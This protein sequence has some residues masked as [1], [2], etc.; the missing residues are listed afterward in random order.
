MAKFERG[1]HPSPLLVGGLVLLALAA[2][3]LGAYTVIGSYVDADGWLHE[4][5]AFIPLAWL[6]GLAGAVLFVVV[7]VV[8]VWR[9]RRRGA[10]QR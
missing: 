7:V 2:A 5:F 4:P 9:G 3:L 10:R 6:S 1:G 8:A